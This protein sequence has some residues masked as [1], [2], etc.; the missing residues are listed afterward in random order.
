LATNQPQ[1][2]CGHRKPDQWD[3]NGHAND[4]DQQRDAD[5]EECPGFGESTETAAH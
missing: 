3:E 2:D 1:E 5:N 4:E